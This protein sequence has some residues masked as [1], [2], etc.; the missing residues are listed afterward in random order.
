[1][2][3][4]L[5]AVSLTGSRDKNNPQGRKNE[6]TQVATLAAVETASSTLVANSGQWYA[7]GGI[8]QNAVAL[9]RLIID[10]E[11]SI[12]PGYRI[13]CQ[14]SEETNTASRTR[15]T[16]TVYVRAVLL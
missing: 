5:V 2:S 13:E 4:G 8:R 3:L 10:N 14:I 6:L 15:R 12:R 11:L 1:M 9:Q 7:L 16:Q